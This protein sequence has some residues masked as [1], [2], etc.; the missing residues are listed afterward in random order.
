MAL[1]VDKELDGFD[2]EYLGS[3]T[4]MFYLRREGGELQPVGELGTYPDE[5]TIAAAQA[6]EELEEQGECKASCID[7]YGNSRPIFIGDRLFALMGDQIVE[8]EV[9][10]GAMREVRRIN[11]AQ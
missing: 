10:G 7:W 8:G 3:A 6:M 5:A 1:P 11:F 9:E 4:A 2:L